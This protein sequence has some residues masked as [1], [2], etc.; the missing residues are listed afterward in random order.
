MRA[1]VSRWTRG[2]AQPHPESTLRGAQPQMDGD[3]TTQE[4]FHDTSGEMT[5]A[6]VLTIPL[7]A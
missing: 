5:G 7:N 4:E 2:F 1:P 3:L 6:P